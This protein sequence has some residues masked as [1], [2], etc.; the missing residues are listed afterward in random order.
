[1]II[2]IE[3][4]IFCILF[5]IGALH[6]IKDPIKDIDNYPPKIIERCLELGLITK[7]AT[8]GSKKVLIKKLTG[9]AVF[10][11]AFAV[12]VHFINGAT[13]FLQG[14]GISF[15]LWNIIDWYDAFILDCVW[16]CHSKRIIIPGTEDMVEEYKNYKFHLLGSLKGMVLGVP[17]CMV[18]GAICMIL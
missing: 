14:F 5:T 3:S 4:V 15:L 7:E 2:L 6:T 18:V 13:T 17:I 11:V 12:A 10:I 16:F 1:M 8:P 9:A